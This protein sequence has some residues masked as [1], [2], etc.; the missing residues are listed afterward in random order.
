M[1]DAKD[2]L[3]KKYYTYSTSADYKKYQ[4]LALMED[5]STNVAMSNTIIDTAF[6]GY[7]TRTPVTKGNIVGILLGNSGTTLNQPVQEN[8]N[9]GSFT[10][11][12]VVN[13]SSGYIVVF[14]NRKSVSGT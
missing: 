12:D 10:G 2:P 9:V 1:S 5:S 3:D 7:D 8:Y 14:G 11:V 6:A 4:L 13:T